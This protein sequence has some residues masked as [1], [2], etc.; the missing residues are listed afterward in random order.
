MGLLLQRLP[1]FQPGLQPG[2]PVSRV[3]LVSTD[4]PPGLHLRRTRQPGGGAGGV[5]GVGHH[6]VSMVRHLFRI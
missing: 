3:D 5:G 1:G 2:L 4:P 6:W